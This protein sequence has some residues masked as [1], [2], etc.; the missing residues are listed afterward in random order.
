MIGDRI[1]SR[2]SRRATG[3]GPGLIRS[4]KPIEGWQTFS[5]FDDALFA[6]FFTFASRSELVATDADAGILALNCEMTRP[7]T[8]TAPKQTS[9]WLLNPIGVSISC[10]AFDKNE[11]STFIDEAR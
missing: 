6:G 5:G 2:R 7:I 4:S 1:G 9:P 10:E 11:R 8:D 3:W